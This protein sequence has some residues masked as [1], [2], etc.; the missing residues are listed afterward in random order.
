[1]VEGASARPWSY[2]AAEYPR[3]CVLLYE[4]LAGDVLELPRK[5]M[6]GNTERLPVAGTSTL[7]S[8]EVWNGRSAD[9][10]VTVQEYARRAIFPCWLR[11]RPEEECCRYACA[12]AAAGSCEHM[13]HTSRRALR[14]TGDDDSEAS[15]YL[16]SGA[17]AYILIAGGDCAIVTVN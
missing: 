10:T 12:E 8:W 16:R 13:Q 9:A 11:D 1:M 4:R 2:P 5:I 15:A 14:M 6:R 3:L 7:R 17:R